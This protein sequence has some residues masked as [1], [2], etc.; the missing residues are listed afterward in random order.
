MRTQEDN[1]FDYTR[2]IVVLISDAKYFLGKKDLSK[3]SSQKWLRCILISI[4]ELDKLS[5]FSEEG[6]VDEVTSRTPS[7]I[8]IS[9]NQEQLDLC[10]DGAWQALSK[11]VLYLKIK[12]STSEK[13]ILY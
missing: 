11:E 4:T 5:A 1:L 7:F 13:L 2:K 9:M 10:Q 8:R 12:N 6:W 3:E